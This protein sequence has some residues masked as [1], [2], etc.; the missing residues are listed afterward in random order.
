MWAVQTKVG[1]LYACIELGDQ[2]KSEGGLPDEIKLVDQPEMVLR[3]TCIGLQKTTYL[4][5]RHVYEY[6][7]TPENFPWF[8]DKE[9]WIEYL[10]MMVENRYNSL[11]LWNGHHVC[12]IGKT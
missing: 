10:D 9:H 6:P 12:I 1:V 4:P 2:I 7:Y 3:G 11:Y 5:G 8:Y